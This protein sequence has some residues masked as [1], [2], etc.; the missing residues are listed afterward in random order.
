MEA[1]FKKTVT[2]LE[3]EMN[4]KQG[5]FDD[6]N[7]QLKD[8]QEKCFELET[9]NDALTQKYEKANTELQKMKDD[10]T[11]MGESLGIQA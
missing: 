8:H 11:K 7:K 9:E 10:F 2:N 6:M 4:I 3:S 5:I 1:N